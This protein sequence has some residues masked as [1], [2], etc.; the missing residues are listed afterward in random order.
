MRDPYRMVEWDS[1]GD[2]QYMDDYY[3]PIKITWRGPR[4]DYSDQ[5]LSVS[6]QESEKKVTVGGEGNKQ[7]P[8]FE[9]IAVLSSFGLA[10]IY[11][12]RERKDKV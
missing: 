10:A 1:V 4:P 5:Y 12:K 2:G 6:F 7:I 3:H 9:M 11:K 8:G